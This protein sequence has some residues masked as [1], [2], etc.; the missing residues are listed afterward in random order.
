MNCSRQAEARR[1]GTLVSPT[2]RQIAVSVGVFCLAFGVGLPEAAA[3]EGGLDLTRVGTYAGLAL[4]PFVLVLVTSFMKFSI[5]LTFL[6]SAI[7]IQQVPSGLVITAL[8]ALLSAYVMAPVGLDMREAALSRPELLENP[9][10]ADVIETMGDVA[11][12]LREWLVRHSGEEESALFVDM[13]VELHQGRHQEHF[14]LGSPLIL[15]PAFVLTELKE[16]FIIGFII[17]L[18]FLVVDLVVSN[19]LL[20]LGM[21]MMSPTTVSLPFKLLLFVL[22]DGWTLIVHGLVMGYG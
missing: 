9:S 2:T 19:I 10:S 3:E 12:P 1:F 17:L 16:A 22:I 6:R 15:V 5:V 20:S 11:G 21:H 13:A 7:G 18:P 14:A 8:A 4:I